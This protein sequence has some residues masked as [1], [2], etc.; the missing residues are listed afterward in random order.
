MADGLIRVRSIY[1][2]ETTLGNALAAI[3]NRGITIFSVIDHGKNA[4]EAGL[5]LRKSALII[6]GN[7]KTGTVLMQDKPSIAIDLPLRLLVDEEDGKVML[8][9]YNP[10]YLA[11]KHEIDKGLIAINKISGLLN[12]IVMEASGKSGTAMKK[13]T[14]LPGFE[15]GS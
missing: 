11:K 6:F 7:A 4:K 14:P 5:E 13:I 8:R 12:Q 3:K 9:Y 15:P 10:L 1:D 2:F